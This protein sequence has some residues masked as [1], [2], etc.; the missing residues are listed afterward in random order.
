MAEQLLTGQPTPPT[1]PLPLTYQNLFNEAAKQ[2]QRKDVPL[3]NGKYAANAKELELY[4]QTPENQEAFFKGYSR[5]TMMFGRDVSSDVENFKKKISGGLTS[6]EIAMQKAKPSL[7][8]VKPQTQVQQME[9]QDLNQPAITQFD[10]LKANKIN[11]TATGKPLNTYIEMQDYFSN[12]ENVSEWGKAYNYSIK[13]KGFDLNQIANNAKPVQSLKTVTDIQMDAAEQIQRDDLD[14][15]D[16]EKLA[17]LVYNAEELGLVGESIELEKPIQYTEIVDGQLVTKTINEL[18]YENYSQLLKKKYAKSDVNT[19]LIQPG[20]DFDSR[21]LA[22]ERNAVY[23]INDYEQA[24]GKV[25]ENYLDIVAT[26][27]QDENR[28]KIK[29][30]DADVETKMRQLLS[31]DDQ[32]LAQITD[33]IQNLTEQMLMDKFSGKGVSPDFCTKG[34]RKIF[35]K[36]SQRPTQSRKKL[37][38]GKNT[39]SRPTSKFGKERMGKPKHS[40]FYCNRH[41]TTGIGNRRRHDRKECT[42]LQ[43]HVKSSEKESR[44]LW[45]NADIEQTALYKRRCIQKRKRIWSQSSC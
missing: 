10:E 21:Y 45:S 5:A 44:T 43:L 24:I 19:E 6:G 40:R 28:T 39:S 15:V 36:I 8:T 17:E 23:S 7:P 26:K 18:T 30:Y 38:L 4:L 27:Q 13:T 42:T 33:Q 2:E 20:Q 32:K 3:P 16:P 14:Q 25:K 41:G 31:P 37:A 12:P 35:I 1:G 22:D 34:N 11:K 9:Y 29:N